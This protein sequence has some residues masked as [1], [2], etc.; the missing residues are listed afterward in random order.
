MRKSDGSGLSE[1]EGRKDEK[2]TSR[3]NR[4]APTEAKW[5]QTW[6]RELGCLC[7]NPVSFG[8]LFNL[9]VSFLICKMELIETT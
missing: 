7:S 3:N 2:G 8:N 4:S 1:I 6:A 5:L 9:S